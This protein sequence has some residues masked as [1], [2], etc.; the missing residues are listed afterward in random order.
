MGINK[1]AVIF[2]ALL[3]VA[4]IRAE[5]I[6]PHVLLKTDLGNILLELYPRQAPATVDNFIQYVEDYYYDGVIFHRVVRGFVIQ[7]GGYGFDLFPREPGEPIVNESNNGLKNQRGTLAMARLPDPDSARAQFY[8][9][10]ANNRNLDAKKDKPGYTVF[11]KVI[12]GMKVVDTIAKLPTERVDI[13]THL[14]EEPIR[15]LSARLVQPEQP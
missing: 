6:N 12:D 9:N 10:L 1:F 14:P 7:A 5:D 15:I 11:G 2:I 13:F 4:P 8:I 3:A